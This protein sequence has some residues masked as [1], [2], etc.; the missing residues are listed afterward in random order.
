MLTLIDQNSNYQFIYE[1]DSE[2]PRVY[3]LT[4]VAYGL[5]LD[6]T[7]DYGG[8]LTLVDGGGHTRWAFIPADSI[9]SGAWAQ[10][11]ARRALYDVQV[12][13]VRSGKASAFDGALAAA[14]STY[15]DRSS[16]VS[17]LHASAAALFAACAA[18]LGGPLDV[19][20]LFT[21]ADMLGASTAADWTPVSVS[22]SD[23]EFEMY[24]K[25]L[26]LTQTQQVPVGIYD[27][28]M[29]ALYRNDAAKTIR[30]SHENPSIKK[31][32]AEFLGKPGSETAHHV[33]HT[34]YVP[35]KVS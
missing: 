7:W 34:H 30:K 25:T 19:S 33:L 31:I 12:A 26:T 8:H 6:V 29:H 11:K 5:P 14:L 17:Q 16:T 23:G 4:N 13:L 15:S 24:H 35:R 10:Y 18:V 27:V 2:S 21:N 28:V 32:Y 1:E 20:F 22:F 9:S 3:T